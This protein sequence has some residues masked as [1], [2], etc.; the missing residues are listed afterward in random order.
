VKGFVAIGDVP[1]GW[2]SP[3]AV[4]GFVAIGDVPAGWWSPIAVKVYS[5]EELAA[6]CWSED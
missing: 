5:A 4:K 2:W 1:A 3:I 6:N